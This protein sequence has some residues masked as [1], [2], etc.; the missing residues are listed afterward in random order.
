MPGTL[1]NSL[2]LTVPVA[3]QPGFHCSQPRA[4]L[5]LVNAH[6]VQRKQNN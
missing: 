3:R 6:P 4:D 2:A 5:L 1:K